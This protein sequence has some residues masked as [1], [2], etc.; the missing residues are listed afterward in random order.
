MNPIRTI[1][2][3]LVIFGVFA[4]SVPQAQPGYRDQGAHHDMRQGDRR[5]RQRAPYDHRH[6]RERHYNPYGDGG[7]VYGPPPV[8]Y[9]PPTSPGITLFLPLEFR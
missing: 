8:V 3:A 6:D 4:P 1:G 2:L 7:Y 5:E 9:A